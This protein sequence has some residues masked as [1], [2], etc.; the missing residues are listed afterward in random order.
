VYIPGSKEPLRIPI[1]FELGYLFKALPEAVYN[2]AANDEKASK[3]L[4]GV[5]KLVAQTNPFALPQAV[6]PLTEAV[7]GKSFF[8]GDIESQRE[9]QILATQRYRDNSTEVAKLIG[10]VT[11]AVGLSPITIDYL[12]RGYTG[13]LGVA[14][15]SLAN[16]LLASDTRAD[17]AKPSMKPSQMPFIGGLFQPV[18]GR[19]TLD[20]AYDR[21]MEIR[22][23]KGTYNKLIEDGK[24][25]EAQAFV[26]EYSG[27]L[28]A[29]SVS[30]AAQ[31]QL[32]ELAKQERVVKNSPSLTTEQKDA[33]LERLDKIKLQIARNLLKVSDKTTPQ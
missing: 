25:A 14:I 5:A 19:G 23:V 2:M 30:G 33:Q 1:P 9:K 7:L 8:S 10:S 17:V 21:M 4:G 20:E 16:P 28:A 26:Q 27:K 22:Q 13:G 11:G 18:E 29:V 24:R 12:I 3:A 15:V 32:G 6:K 31:K